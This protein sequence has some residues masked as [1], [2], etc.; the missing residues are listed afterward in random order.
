MCIRDSH[1]RTRQP[2]RLP[3]RVR[4]RL[5]HALPQHAGQ[6]GGVHHQLLDVWVRAQ[7]RT[8]PQTATG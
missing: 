6:L 3:A 8:R 7:P 1:R 5:L 4:A 2:P